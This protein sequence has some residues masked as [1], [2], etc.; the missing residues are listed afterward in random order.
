M[1]FASAATPVGANGTLMRLTEFVFGSIR[2]TAWS[3]GVV[4]QT[5]PAPAATSQVV[6]VK[7]LIG[8]QTVCGLAGPTA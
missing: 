6:A 5:A 8:S 1:A 2:H 7:F 4:A 3:R